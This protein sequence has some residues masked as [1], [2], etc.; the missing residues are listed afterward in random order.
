MKSIREGNDY[1]VLYICDG[2]DKDL[3][4]KTIKKGCDA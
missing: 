2:K 4:M 3:E 1:R